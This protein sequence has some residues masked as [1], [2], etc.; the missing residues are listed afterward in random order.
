MKTKTLIFSLLLVLPALAA[1]EMVTLSVQKGN[2]RKSPSGEVIWEA[3]Q[4]TPFK[5]LN[6]QGSW[7]EIEDFE[8]DTGWIHSSILGSSPGVIVKTSKAN[9]RSAPGGEIIW[10]LEKGYPLK[11]IKKEG[12]W[13]N[14]TDDGDTE[15]WLHESTVWGFS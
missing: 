15:G 13:Y 5:V 11:V 6:R 7:V 12:A 10:V 8:E 14:V 1:A 3:Y 4:Y 2:V 9:L